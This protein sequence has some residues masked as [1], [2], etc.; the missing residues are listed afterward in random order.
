MSEPHPFFATHED[1][2]AETKTVLTTLAREMEKVRDQLYH[3]NKTHTVALMA[4]DIYL[5]SQVVVEAA[6]IRATEIYRE[7]QKTLEEKP[8]AE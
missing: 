2:E 7:V 1:L 8:N 3:L 4:A 6:A 5:H